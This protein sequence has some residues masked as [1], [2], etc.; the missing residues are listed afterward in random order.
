MLVDKIGKNDALCVGR[1]GKILWEGRRR[2]WVDVGGAS[3]SGPA[4]TSNWPDI[5]GVV[6]LLNYREIIEI[7]VFL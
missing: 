7:R 4:P 6:I 2:G 5:A 3:T 1:R